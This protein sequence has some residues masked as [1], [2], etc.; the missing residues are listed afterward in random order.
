MDQILR[1]LG[2]AVSI[3]ALAVI[4][5]ISWNAW[6]RIEPGAKVPISY[7]RAGDP[8]MRL[9]KPFALVVTP[10]IATVLLLVLNIPSKDPSAVG[11]LFTLQIAAA[12]GFV[13]VHSVQMR[14]ALDVLDK[15]GQLRS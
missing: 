5:S 14:H 8:N 4:A 7:N 6:K 3:A 10:I 2:E 1:T 12:I 13:A 9:K 11:I 15:E